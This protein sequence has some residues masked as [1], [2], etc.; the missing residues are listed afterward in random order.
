M[1]QIEVLK[2]ASN[3]KNNKSRTLNDETEERATVRPIPQTTSAQM[4]REASVLIPP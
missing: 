1:Y 2:K 3:K 4:A